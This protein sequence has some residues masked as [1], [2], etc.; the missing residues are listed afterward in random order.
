VIQSGH[1][2][3]SQKSKPDMPHFVIDCSRNV[4]NIKTAD[5]IMQAVYE[6]A[7]S[8]KLF[9]E[10]DIKIRINPYEHYK[11]G[12]GKI[13]FLHIFGNIMEGRTTEQ[14]ANLSRLILQKLNTILPDVSILSINIR[15]FELATYCNKAMLDPKNNS[16]DRFF[17]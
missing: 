7:E 8:T 4:L 16:N 6:A 13:S 11:L 12:E 10:N 9:K 2:Y 15:E 17:K 3:Y 5:E 14:K 1:S